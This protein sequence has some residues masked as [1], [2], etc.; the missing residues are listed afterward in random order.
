MPQSNGGPLVGMITDMIVAIGLGQELRALIVLIKDQTRTQTLLA[1][2]R[3]A[4][5]PMFRG[6]SHILKPDVLCPRQLQLPQNPHTLVHQSVQLTPVPTQRHTFHFANV[7][8]I[9]ELLQ[10]VF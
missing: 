8:P 3:Q 4:A 2:H 10:L 9:E 6:S 7:Q 1:Y 5:T